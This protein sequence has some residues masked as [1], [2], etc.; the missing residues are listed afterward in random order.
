MPYLKE[1]NL[2]IN[3]LTYFK[4]LAKKSKIKHKVSR[5]QE[6]ISVWKSVKH[7]IEKL[8]KFDETKI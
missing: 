6:I 4:N 7:K 1:R 5:K 2:K 3:N 8:Q